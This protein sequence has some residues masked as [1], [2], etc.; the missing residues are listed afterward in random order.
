MLPDFTATMASLTP[1]L[2][3]AAALWGQA[4]LLN[5]RCLRPSRHHPHHKR[6][7]SGY[8]TAG[9][10]WTEVN[11]EGGGTPAGV[12][13]PALGPFSLGLRASDAGSSACHAVSCSF[14]YGLI[15]TPPVALHRLPRGNRSY[16]VTLPGLRQGA[17]LNRSDSAPSQARI[18]SPLRDYRNYKSSRLPPDRFQ[19][20]TG[21]VRR[22]PGAEEK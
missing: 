9:P 20:G 2:R 15:F 18:R 11:A 5:S 6:P 14:Y 12:V 22:G 4:S 3:L 19:F 21:E 10:S 16:G 8:C 7:C 13:S 1:A 17:D